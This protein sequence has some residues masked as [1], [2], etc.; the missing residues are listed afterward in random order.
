MTAVTDA[1]VDPTSATLDK[2]TGDVYS[3]TVH[4]SIVGNE[5]YLYRRR[6]VELTN[7]SGAGV[8]AGDVV[9]IGTGT[10]S[11]FTTTTTESDPLAL[12]VAM[13]TI[14]ND[15]V[16]KIA[17]GGSVDVLVTATTTRGQYI[18]TSTTVKQGKPTTVLLPGAFARAVEARTGSGLV[19]CL[20]FGQAQLPAVITLD[21]DVAELEVVNTVTETTVYSYTVPGGTLGT[22]RAL[23]LTMVGDYLNNSGVSSQSLTLRCKYGGTLVGGYQQDNNTDADRV[24]VTFD[25]V[26]SAANA[27]NAQ[28]S[29]SLCFFGENASPS[30]GSPPT[31]T[32]LPKD[33]S[34]SALVNNGLALDSTADQSLIVTV[35]H[36]TANANQSFKCYTVHLE[37]V[38]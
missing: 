4:D 2:S 33:A 37:L 1:W 5:L 27:T 13:D 12:G 17:I 21:R 30:S 18:V 14:A 3:E 8:V 20:L 26:I 31:I 16:G 25:V 11:S 35:Q 24:A 28:R 34:V 15:A 6:V 38:P 23:R 7:K 32:A 22:N 19:K 10:N 29:R 9:I 36:E